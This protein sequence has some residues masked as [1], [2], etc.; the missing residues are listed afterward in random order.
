MLRPL[1]HYARIFHQ[2][3]SKSNPRK[4]EHFDD[5]A[6]QCHCHARMVGTGPRTRMMVM[7]VSREL[8]PLPHHEP[9]HPFQKAPL[10][11]E[12]KRRHH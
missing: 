11:I 1:G 12:K 5:H 2:R 10:E 9:I 4:L 3:L 7:C 8:S 6:A